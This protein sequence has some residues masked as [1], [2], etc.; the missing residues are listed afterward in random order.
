[1]MS[2]DHNYLEGLRHADMQKQIQEIRGDDHGLAGWE[3]ELRR[4]AHAQDTRKNWQGITVD[5]P[6][7]NNGTGS[8]INARRETIPDENEFL[9]GM[10]S[11]EMYPIEHDDH[12]ISK[13]LVEHVNKLSL[14]SARRPPAD[15]R[16]RIISD[17]N[18]LVA[19]SRLIHTPTNTSV[20]ELDWHKDDGFVNNLEVDEG[21]RHMTNYFA[22]QAWNHARSK[23]WYGPASSYSLS[24]FSE[25]IVKKYNPD[26]ADFKKFRTEK[27][28]QCP[29]CRD[30][31]GLAVLTPHPINGG[32]HVEYNVPGLHVALV[33]NTEDEHLNFD[34]TSAHRFDVNGVNDQTEIR[35][36]D[37]GRTHLWDHLEIRCPNCDGSGLSEQGRRQFDGPGLD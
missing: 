30:N 5:E 21:H 1:M 8:K 31:P 20:G 11:Q 24:P 32:R 17:P 2:E 35:N 6:G 7:S 28:A 4:A 23:G 15:Y 33:P 22:T 27:D 29:S 19:R 9:P 18:G 16:V 3:E 10:S 13:Q 26:S 25:K 36:P 12:N 37:T 14:M 34:R